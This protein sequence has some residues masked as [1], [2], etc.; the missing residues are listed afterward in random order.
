MGK[1]LGKEIIDKMY[2]KRE[3]LRFPSH[4]YFV[5]LPL[6]CADAIRFEA[7]PT[8]CYAEELSRFQLS[9]WVYPECC[10]ASV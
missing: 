7:Q 4:F 3:N 1:G 5:L 6:E 8:F 10:D 9:W 2:H